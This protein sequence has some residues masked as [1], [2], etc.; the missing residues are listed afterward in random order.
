MVYL[1][2][3]IIVAAIVYAIAR[4]ATGNSYANMTEQQFEREAKR[5]SKVAA[6]VIG[7]QKA[8]DPGHRVE[9]PQAQV[10]RA[11]A[12]TAALGDS[13]Q[14]AAPGAPD[15]PAGNSELERKIVEEG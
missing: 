4:A 2:V 6:A 3:G 1:V 13:P 15:R 5:S 8:V 10:L 7:L 12:D 9:Y 11:E 14:T